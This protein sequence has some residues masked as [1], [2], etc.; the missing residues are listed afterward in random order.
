MASTRSPSWPAAGR[1]RLLGLILGALLGVVYHVT[2]TPMF[3]SSAQVLVIRSVDQRSAGADARSAVIDDYVGAQL[4]LIKSERVRMATAKIL[5]NM[6]VNT[7]LPE[8]NAGV[9]E[10]VRVGLTVLR[11]KDAGAASAVGNGILILSFRWADAADAKVFLDAVIKAYEAELASVYSSATK[12]QIESQ[13]R[14]IDA[15]KASLKVANEARIGR[16]T[17]LQKITVEAIASVQARVTEQKNKLAAL[18]NEIV[19]LDSAVKLIAD[20]GPNAGQRAA[21]LTQLTG[22]SNVAL[23]KAVEP[24][25]DQQLRVTQQKRDSLSQKLGPKHPDM[26]ALDAE[27][28]VHQGHHCS[29]QPDQ[30]QWCRGRTGGDWQEIRIHPGVQKTAVGETECRAGQR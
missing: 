15:T 19:E 11:D 9:A 29:A 8:S 27:I 6:P 21:V 28:Q 2:S 22:V 5:R 25:L 23:I 10:M 1:W 20:A 12:E 24:G 18:D 4:A 26:L 16:E 14:G 17:D 7:P 30:P 3:L 13:R